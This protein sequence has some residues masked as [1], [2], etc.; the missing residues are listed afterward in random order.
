MSNTMSSAIST[1]IGERQIIGLVVLAFGL[2]LLAGAGFAG[3]DFV[4][5]A[6]HD[7]R[8]AIGF[9]CH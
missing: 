6:A 9:P 8:H 2:L 3:S 7:T 1:S 5:N 4:H